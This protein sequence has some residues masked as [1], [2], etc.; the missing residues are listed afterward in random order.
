ME[1]LGLTSESPWW[2]VFAIALITAILGE[3]F[4]PFR[5]LSTSTVRRWVG[6]GVLMTVSSLLVGCVYGISGIALALALQGSR[7][8]IANTL[9]VPFA[10]QLGLGFLALDFGHYLAHR[11]LH[12]F[13]ALWLIHQVHHSE[14]DLDATTGLRFH[15]G[16]ALFTQAA[17]LL[18]VALLGVPPLAVLAAALATLMQDLFTHAN[19]AVPN[20]VDRALRWILITPGLHRTHHSDAIEEQNTNFGTIL[21]IWD[22]LFGTYLEE[23]VAGGASWGLVE[24]PNGSLLG[25]SRLLMLPFVRPAKTVMAVNELASPPCPIVVEQ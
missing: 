9:A 18:V 23:P 1:L 21:S 10:V 5:H 15:P 19:I 4:R 24:H 12:R 8:G 3:T 7:Y 14:S 13:N 6:N 25:P 16:E 11:L 22:R 20:R 2:W 17:S